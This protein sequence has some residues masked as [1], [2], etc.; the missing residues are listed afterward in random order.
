MMKREPTI[1]RE[2][3]ATLVVTLIMLVLLTLF[4]ISA[5][6]S[7]MVNLR[8]AG[9]MQAQDEGRAA[10]QVAIERLIS[11]V[12]NIQNINSLTWP[13]IV[14][15]DLNNDGTNDYRVSIAKPF[16][17]RAGP[18]IPGRTNECVAGEKAKLY[19]LDTIWEV[20]ATARELRSGVLQQT[21][22]QQTVQ[23]AAVT[24]PPTVTPSLINC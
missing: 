17:M 12:N 6:N 9:N 13:R 14:D 23:G 8:I 1:Y 10:G 5:I 19:C 11:D 15:V 3:G 16:C 7:G 21:V 22:V 4:A 20:T 18:Q 2:Q 24:F